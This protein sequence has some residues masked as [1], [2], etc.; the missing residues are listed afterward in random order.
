VQVLEHGGDEGEGDVEPEGDSDGCCE[1]GAAGGG[2]V[3]L[4]EG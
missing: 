2:A 1:P 4:G 3:D